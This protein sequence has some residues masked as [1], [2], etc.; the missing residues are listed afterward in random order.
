MSSLW[1]NYR[2]EP[3]LHN[4]DDITDFSTN[5]NDSISF[6]LKKKLQKKTGNNSTK[7]VEIIIPLKH[8]NNF[9]LE[10]SLFN[11]EIS[12]MSKCS[13]NYFFISGTAANQVPTLTI[14]DRIGHVPVVTLSTQGNVK[15]LE[16]LESGF[17]I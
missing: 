6:K 16:Q 11:C 14:T 7:Y 12:L 17:K 13:K 15:Q 3:I 2:I 1:Q 10:M 4:N 8:L 5:S 9:A